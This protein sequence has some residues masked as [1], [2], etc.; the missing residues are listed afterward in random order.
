MAIIITTTSPDDFS[1]AFLRKVRSGR[2][3]TWIIDE[4]G[5]LTISSP[6]WRNMAWFEI[7]V[8]QTQVGFGIIPSAIC[9]MTKELYAVFHG[10]LAA[11]LLAYFDDEI[12]DMR[13]T[14]QFDERFDTL[15]DTASHNDAV[16]P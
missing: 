5:D 16:A 10:R 4:D 8:A 3:P 1:A 7:Q 14:P 13:I 9:R 2:I 15:P 12:S 11:T 6:R